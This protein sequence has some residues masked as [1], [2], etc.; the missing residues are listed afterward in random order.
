MSEPIGSLCVIRD[1]SSNHWLVSI[2]QG[3]G[4]RHVL[5][6]FESREDASEYAI[7]ERAR[8]TQTVAGASMSIHF[9]NDC[10]CGGEGMKW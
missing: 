1:E 2:C 7:E 9:P 4:Y 10:P 3:N 5:R 8:R 6:R